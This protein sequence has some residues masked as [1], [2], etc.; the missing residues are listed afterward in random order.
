VQHGDMA[1]VL[2]PKVYRRLA[3]MIGLSGL[4]LGLLMQRLQGLD[5]GTVLRAMGEVGGLAWAAALGATWVS[6]RAVAGYDLA[7]HRHL[8]TGIAADRARR[9]GFAAIAIGQ[10]VGLGVISG[11]L[12]RWRMLPELGFFGAMRL[13]LLVALSFLLAWSVVC[14]VVLSFASVGPLTWLAPAVLGGFVILGVVVLVWPRP[15]MPNLIT[16]GRLVA[17]A[18][19][20][21][22][23]AGLAL[24]LLV[25]GALG[26]AAFL[27]VFLLAL[28]AGLVSGAPAGLGA[29]E[30]VLLALLPGVA[31]A[32]LLAGILAWRVT[33]YAGP[34][35]A[36]AVVALLARPEADGQRRAPR[37]APPIPAPEV[38]EG[39]LIAQGDLAIHPAGFIAGR[40]RH[41]LVALGEVADLAAF[42]AAATDEGRW[43][44]IYKADPR[45]AARARASGMAVLPVALEAWL[46]P[47]DFRLELSSRAGLRRKLRKAASA[48]IA[49]AENQ[50]DWLALAAVNQAWAAAR[51]G[52]HGFSMGRFD[53]AYLAGQ[54]VVVARQGDCVVGFAS[55]HRAHLDGEMVWTLDLLRPDPSAPDGTA[56]SLVMAALQAARSEGVHR[57]S[58]AAVPVGCQKDER[59]IVARLGRR[60]AAPLRGLCQFKTGFAPNWQRL[61]IAGPGLAALALVGGEIWGRVRNPPALPIMSPTTRPHEEY[62]IAMDR[63]PWQREEDT[64]A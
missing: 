28:G 20:D 9:A 32:D 12:V 41:G 1:R 33:Y 44:V 34:A 10:T 57:L 42:R 36:G 8:A 55:F 5:P 48:V 40:T 64:L 45:M 23:F 39:W 4:F 24:W 11:A 35:L 37:P 18:A 47:Q 49:A 13:S 56:H 52:E 60:P 25:P 6:F 59:G 53:P 26:F 63:N 3:L 51:G 27:P 62:E 2:R 29:F 7:L 38:A 31:Q 21:C 14:A 50:P 15:W 43:P 46:D 16:Q 17:L 61:Y 30:I 54:L 22:L 58:L 19:V